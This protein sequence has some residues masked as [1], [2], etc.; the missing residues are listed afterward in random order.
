MIPDMLNE[1][2]SR[3]G[4]GCA[5][6]NLGGTDPHEMVQRT[7][8]N[9]DHAPFSPLASADKLPT[10]VDKTCDAPYETTVDQEGDIDKLTSSPLNPNKEVFCKL[11]SS[12][13]RSKFNR[14]NKIES[15]TTKNIMKNR[16]RI[17]LKNK[18]KFGNNKNSS[19]N[20]KG[21]S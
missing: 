1:R 11:F 5:S 9:A 15:V 16:L 20:E 19:R 13:L 14:V 18:P 21:T 4:F 17:I 10:E 12:K 7:V 6:D 3:V 2:E 8:Y